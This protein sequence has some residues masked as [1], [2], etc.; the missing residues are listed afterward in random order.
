MF[1]CVGHLVQS[2]CMVIWLQTAI[3][4]IYAIYVIEA[5]WESQIERLQSYFC[6]TKGHTRA[7]AALICPPLPHTG[8]LLIQLA[9]QGL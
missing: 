3:G 4:N 8:Y 6:R 7:K 5:R 9:N 2:I 1:G